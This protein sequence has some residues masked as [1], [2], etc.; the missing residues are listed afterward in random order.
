MLGFEPKAAD[1]GSKDANQ[2][3]MLP[4][5]SELGVSD[6][7]DASSWR[8]IIELESSLDLKEEPTC[9]KL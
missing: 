9:S 6:L 5:G 1:S 4:P 3:A 7:C 2:C 8:K